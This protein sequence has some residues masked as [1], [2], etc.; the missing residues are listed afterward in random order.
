MP[1][2]GTVQAT[3]EFA[4]SSSGDTYAIIDAKYM[5]DGFRN[6][7]TIA[8]LDSITT[9]R[10]IAGMVAGVSGGTAY[11][12]LNPE[13]WAYT[14]SDWSTFSTGSS[15]ST[16]TGNTSGSCITDLYIS[17]LYGCSPITV[18]DD[19]ILTTNKKI[20]GG[21]GE[22]DFYGSTGVA[23]TSDNS[24]Y[25]TPYI[26]VDSGSS[27]SIAGIY[28][29]VNGSQIGVTT[30][31]SSFPLLGNYITIFPDKTRI[32]HSDI[33]EIGSGNSSF[34]A[35]AIKISSTQGITGK[36][37]NLPKNGVIISSQNSYLQ[38]GVTNSVIL[39]GSNIIATSNDTVYVP[40]LNISL[41]ASGTSVTNLGIDINGNVVSGT[42]ASAQ[43][44][45]IKYNILSGE[46]V[47]IA[48]DYE[49]FVYGNLTLEGTI[50]NSGKIVIMNGAFI[51]SGGTY[52]QLSGGSLTLVS[53][54][55]I[56]KY[57]ITTGL[58]A[59][60]PLVITHNLGTPDVMITVKDLNTGY[61]IGVDEYSYNL[62]DVTVESTNTLTNI[63]ITIVG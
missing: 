60:T 43:T 19:I 48:A 1:I 29:D 15:G 9:D 51:N 7:D 35:D 28:D 46:T 20:I 53:S 17:N 22:I 14:F 38:T 3:G 12:K 56:N 33:L 8:D 63:R 52:N 61:K 57:S 50:N 2:N 49:Y 32:Y 55:T 59:N 44:T 42:T 54:Q 27:Q 5:R 47:D 4:P 31:N 34:N 30:R 24:N 16:F 26:W 45:G 40:Y 41:L 11:Y 10:R 13:P 23:L 18:H 37:N 58:T 39:G 6:V 36:T 25:A 62:N 21:T